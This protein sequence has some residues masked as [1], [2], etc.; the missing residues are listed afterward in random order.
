MEVEVRVPGQVSTYYDFLLASFQVDYQAATG[1]VLLRSDIKE[2]LAYRKTFGAK[3]DQSV[4]IRL[5]RLVENEL[6][7]VFIRSNR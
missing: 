1:Q 3:G 5:H 7:E 2:G 6:Y 4:A